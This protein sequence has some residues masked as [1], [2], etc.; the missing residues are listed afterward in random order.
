MINVDKIKVVQEKIKMA[1]LRIE[2]E[3][4]ITITFGSSKY[5]A[6]HYTIDDHSHTE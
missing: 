4:N 5:D 1:L 6:S 3:E 2:E